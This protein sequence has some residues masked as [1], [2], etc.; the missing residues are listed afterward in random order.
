M[1][2]DAVSIQDIS[3]TWH[4]AHSPTLT[5]AGIRICK[6]FAIGVRFF[7]LNLS[8]VLSTPCDTVL[9]TYVLT[10]TVQCVLLQLQYT[11]SSIIDDARKS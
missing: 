2:T 5:V 10:S 3:P 1:T 11:R 8:C 7:I 4:M 9:F 6:L